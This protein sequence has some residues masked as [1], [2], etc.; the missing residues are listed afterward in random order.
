M[1]KNIILIILTVMLFSCITGC[2][3]INSKD[4]K[5]DIVC[6]T[7]PQYDW[8]RNIIGENDNINL[9]LLVD[10][11]TDLHSF[12]PSTDDIITISTADI[13]IFGGGESEQWVYDAILQKKNDNMKVV[14]LMD[15]LG[16]NLVEEDHEFTVESSIEEVEYS[17]EPENDEH[18]WLSLKNVILLCTKITD[19][20]C[21]LDTDNKDLYVQNCNDYIA[22]LSKLDKEYETVV[23]SAEFD[24]VI[25]GDR[26]PLIYMFR[27]YGI[28]YYA[29]FV[30][31]TAE[32]EASF[33][34]VTFL[35]NKLDDLKVPAL[36]VI[37]G[38]DCKFASTIVENSNEK[39]TEILAINS[40]QSITRADVENG[41]TY[42]SIMMNNLDV[43]KKTLNN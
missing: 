28:K 39:N 23:K 34:T 3:T 19:E 25:I 12:Q 30:G 9:K 32:T 42:L 17:E 18:I 2:N 33:E 38:S 20:I 10:N 35:A 1:K 31:C 36:L 43:L 37:E 7:F 4:D 24:T 27:D 15:V 41:V 26:F 5:I 13:L 8:C 21:D 40:M 16:D 6:T 22:E 14:N 29:A 11:G